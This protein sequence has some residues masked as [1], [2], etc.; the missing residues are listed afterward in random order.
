MSEI[1]TDVNQ[2]EIASL[3]HIKGQPHI[4]ELLRTSL[5]AYFQNRAI[6][7]DKTTFGPVLLVGPS[8]TGKTAI[9]KAIHCELANLKFVETNGEMLNS[10]TE[11]THIL[12]TADSD[13]TVL[14]DEAQAFCLGA[15]HLAVQS[16]LLLASLS[17]LV[18]CTATAQA[19]FH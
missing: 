17:P 12:L 9:A 3:N 14:V 18:F 15:F 5:D 4:I 1:G 11:L 13:T 7:Q 2:T 10:S 6:K 8:G 19:G 16:I